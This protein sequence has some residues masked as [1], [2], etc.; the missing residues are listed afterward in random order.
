[1]PPLAPL[2]RRLISLVYEALILAALLMA[3]TLPILLLTRGWDAAY[4]RFALRTG[5]LIVCGV[6]YVAQWRGTGQTLPMKTWRMRLALANGE[7][8]GAPRATLRYLAALASL[9]TLGAGFLWALLDKDKQFLHDRVCG[10]R[11]FQAQ[12]TT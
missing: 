9:I 12:A 10:T 6:F 5:L 7:P 2:K 11:I 4:A 1:M 8:I 3:A